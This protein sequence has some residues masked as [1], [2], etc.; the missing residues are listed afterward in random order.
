MLHKE[1]SMAQAGQPPVAFACASGSLGKGSRA[2]AKAGHPW[3]SSPLVMPTVCW[4]PRLPLQQC[5]ASPAPWSGR[6]CDADTTAH[7]CPCTLI[8]GWCWGYGSSPRHSRGLTICCESP[9]SRSPGALAARGAV[10]SLAPRQGRAGDTLQSLAVE[11]VTALST[12]DWVPV[13]HRGGTDSACSWPQRHRGQE[14][15]GSG[16]KAAQ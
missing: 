7:S 4:C 16:P 3:S 1:F 15:P 13:K 6:I 11:N 2:L 10:N 8:P 5:S 14:A 12:L 9:S